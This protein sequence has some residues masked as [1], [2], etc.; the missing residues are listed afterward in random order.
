MSTK[1]LCGQTQRLSI[2]KEEG[3]SVRLLDFHSI[4]LDPPVMGGISDGIQTIICNSCHSHRLSGLSH[5]NQLF[6][7]ASVLSL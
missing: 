2:A 1:T 6:Q 5:V 3:G 4:L 7:Q